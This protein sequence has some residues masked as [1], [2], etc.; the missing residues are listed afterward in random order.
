M[1]FFFTFDLALKQQPIYILKEACAKLLIEASTPQRSRVLCD[2][3]THCHLWHR[4][5]FT[6]K[7]QTDMARDAAAT[8][9]FQNH[10]LPGISHASCPCTDIVSRRKKNTI[11][12]KTSESSHRE[13]ARLI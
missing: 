2:K 10:R 4:M 11:L 8:S 1:F 7:T 13:L 6:E 12:I 3:T 9:N 5:Q